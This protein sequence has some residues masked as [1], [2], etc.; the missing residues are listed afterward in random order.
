MP[1]T[2]SGYTNF[3]FVVQDTKIDE[4]TPAAITVTVNVSGPNGGASV[5]A[6]GMTR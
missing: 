5:S 4:V 6:S 1:D 3:S 2:Q